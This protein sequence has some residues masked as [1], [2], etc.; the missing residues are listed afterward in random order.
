MAGAN[1]RAQ[2]RRPWLRCTASEHGHG[3]R[4]ADAQAAEHRVVELARLA[5]DQEPVAGGGGRRRLA[6][7]VGAEALRRR[8]PVHDEGAAPDPGGLRLDQVQDQ[9]D[10]DRGVGGAAAGAKDFQA[11]LDR[12]GV[13]RGDH[14]RGGCGEAAT[15]PA[16]PRFR[17]PRRSWAT[18]GTPK[19]AAATMATATK[20]R[21]RTAALGITAMLDV[22]SSTRPDPHC[23]AFSLPWKSRA[24]AVGR[25]ARIAYGTSPC[26]ICGGKRTEPAKD[27]VLTLGSR[28]L[29][30]RP[31][32]VPAT[33][34]P[35]RAGAAAQ[36]TQA[37]RSSFSVWR[38]LQPGAGRADGP[39]Q[40]GR[41]QI[42]TATGSN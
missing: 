40:I 23:C 6:S 30:L 15:V 12:M 20:V 9:L 38:N 8:I 17:A 39:N 14:V 24:Q 3:A 4:H 16:G 26:A 28:F 7:I 21:A 10:G 27:L 11:R 41:R 25:P 13:G 42:E 5:V 29:G 31:R 36:G 1:S 18:A 32:R 2:G 19:A 37:V 22:P 34:R 35:L 33:L